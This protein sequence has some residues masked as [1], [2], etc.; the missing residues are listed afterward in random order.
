MI[1]VNDGSTDNSLQVVEELINNSCLNI[2]VVNK[3]NGGHGSTINVGIK[4]SK[5]KFFKVIDGDDWVDVPNFEKLLEELKGIDV[6]MIIT[7][8]TE[9]HTY[10]QTEKEISFLI[11]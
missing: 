8:Y 1:V 2:R 10:N 7:N 5:G 9:Q 3:E 11:F 4:E 6:D